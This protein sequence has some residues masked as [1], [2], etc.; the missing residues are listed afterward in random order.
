MV[1]LPSSDAKNYLDK[2][3]TNEHDGASAEDVLEML[4]ELARLVDEEYAPVSLASEE[5]LL[6]GF[7]GR[8]GDEETLD[9]D[10]DQ[11]VFTL[12]RDRLANWTL[13]LAGLQTALANTEQDRSLALQDFRASLIDLTRQHP[14][15]T[16]FN[17]KPKAKILPT[18]ELWARARVIAAYGLFSGEREKTLRKGAA[19]LGLTQPQTR[20]IISNFGSGRE[21][22]ADLTNLVELAKLRSSDG[23]FPDLDALLYPQ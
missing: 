8:K 16:A 1:A 4:T 6:A 11:A 20:K 22:R 18:D 2:W 19:L 5:K 10:Y 7:E 9:A 3:I 15:T 14:G 13:L 23:T 17:V 12:R 21:P